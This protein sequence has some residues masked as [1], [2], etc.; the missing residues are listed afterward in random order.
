MCQRGRENL[1]VPAHILSGLYSGGS[2]GQSKWQIRKS[3]RVPE[4]ITVQMQAAEVIST[5]RAC[6]RFQ[7]QAGGGSCGPCSKPQS[8]PLPQMRER[9]C[10]CCFCC[11]TSNHS[12][13]PWYWRGGVSVLH[14]DVPVASP[15]TAQSLHPLRV[16]SLS[17]C[18]HSH[19]DI[20]GSIGSTVPRAATGTPCQSIYIGMG[21]RI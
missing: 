6:D 8:E 15:L 1:I 17:S 18:K 14:A 7:P 11:P 16:M 2:L 10:C 12:S 13:A 20:R 9:A 4:A 21:P 19:I 3:E 5:D